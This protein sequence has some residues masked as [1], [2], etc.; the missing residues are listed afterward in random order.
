MQNSD[1]NTRDLIARILPWVLL[2]I[3]S[4]AIVLGA[5]AVDIYTEQF[6]VDTLKTKDI[7]SWGQL[8]DF[9]GGVLNPTFSFLALVALLLTLYVQSRELKLS[10]EMAELSRQELEMTREELKNSADALKAQNE[11]IHHQR[12]EQTFFAWLES[13]RKVVES[14]SYS[15]MRDGNDRGW[16][17][18]GN[19]RGALHAAREDNLKAV[20]LLRGLPTVPP[21]TLFDEDVCAIIS[22]LDDTGKR[23][24]LEGFKGESG[25]LLTTTGFAG[26]MTPVFGTLTELLSWID[27]QQ[28]IDADKQFYADIV[29]TQLTWIELYFIAVATSH[30]EWR[31]LAYL[32]GKYAL[33]THIEWWSMDP[34]I[35]LACDERLIYPQEPCDDFSLRNP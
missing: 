29:R 19:G 5:V 23:H 3:T 2:A 25:R 22:S 17:N 16:G 33:L 34:V 15:S 35:T 8:G 14:V 4:I 32:A 6:A 24:V 30:G 27:E 12:F 9:F 28:F 21:E 13:Y 1:I 7:D 31:R 10:R 11:A 20:R 26:E 18:S